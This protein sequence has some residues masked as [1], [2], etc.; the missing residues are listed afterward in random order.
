MSYTTNI[1]AIIAGIPGKLSASL[2][3]KSVASAGWDSAGYGTVA[4]STATSFIASI[5][6]GGGMF[7]RKDKG[8]DEQTTVTIYVRDNI[9]V[10]A[11]S[12]IRQGSTDYRATAVNT[13]HGHKVVTAYV[14]KNGR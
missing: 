9:P 14:T 7:G 10:V 13:W 5:Q 11:D 8:S 3:T 12:I 4:L 1:N 6:Q 2:L